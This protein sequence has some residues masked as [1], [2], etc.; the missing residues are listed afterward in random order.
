MS[1]ISEYDARLAYFAA[2]RTF[3]QRQCTI[4]FALEFYRTWIE[5]DPREFGSRVVGALVGRE[6]DRLEGF[7]PSRHAPFERGEGW[8]A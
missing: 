2:R 1:A 5:L 8:A 7:V 4:E 3:V 6:R